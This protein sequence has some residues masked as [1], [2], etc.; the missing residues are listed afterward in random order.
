MTPPTCSP[1]PARTSKPSAIAVKRR[2]CRDTVHRLCWDAA[3]QLV[4]DTPSRKFFSQQANI[5]AI[6]TNTV[7]AAEQ[8]GLLDRLL[9]DRSLAQVQLYFRYYLGRAHESKRASAIAT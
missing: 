1:V 9:D 4:A 3:R 2:K 6:L 8:A 7:P 5:L